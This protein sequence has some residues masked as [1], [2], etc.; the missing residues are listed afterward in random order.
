MDREQYLRRASEWTHH[1][2]YTEKPRRGAYCP[3]PDHELFPGWQIIIM[4]TS[5]CNANCQHCYIPYKG[6]FDPKR[7][8]ELI[9]SFQTDGYNVYLNGT[10]PLMNPDYLAAFTVADQKIVM[11]NGMVLCERPSYIYDIYDAGIETIG[12]SYHFDAQAIF[13]KIPLRLSQTALE[14]TKNA[15]IHARVMT[16][17]T[18]PYLEKIPEYCEWCVRHGFKEIRFTNF[19][20]QGKA[21][22]LDR[23]LILDA[24]DRK[25]YY[26][27]I[28]NERAK[29]DIEELCITSC[30]SFGACGSPNMA[31][32]AMRDFVVLTPEFKVYP[33]FFQTQPG[34]ECGIYHGGHIF[35]IKNF[36]P[37]LHDCGSLHL[38]ND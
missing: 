19:M 20:A 8:I 6:A 31:C 7:L 29:Y 5:A 3:F 38:F 27:I 16:T 2:P 33:C 36:L 26:E 21:R 24:D 18:K 37:P 1:H 10:E 4:V 30:G 22:Q 11:T 14:I 34:M 9:R 32:M 28:S 12:V 17:V 35:T 13:N 25:R 15:G 23:D